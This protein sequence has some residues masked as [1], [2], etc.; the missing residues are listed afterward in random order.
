MAAGARGAQDAGAGTTG[1]ILS[2]SPRQANRWID[3]VIQA[4]SLWDRMRTL[5][6]RAD[7]FAVLPG[8]T[9]TLAE[10]AM[11]LELINKD[12]IEFAPA[13]LVG[14]YWGPL[15]DLMGDEDILREEY[16]LVPVD[17]VEVRGAVGM[18]DEPE[19]AARWL[20]ANMERGG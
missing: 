10:L 14:G 5:M 13:A 4:D 19:Q 2:G 11:M 7:A 16:G 20:K 17:G 1:I 8:G 12:V 9:G 15:V 6:A 3:E 18:A